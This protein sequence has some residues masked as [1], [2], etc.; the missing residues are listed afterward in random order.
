M[1]SVLHRVAVAHLKRTKSTSS[2]DADVMQVD[3]APAQTQD[4]PSLEEYLGRCISYDTS[5]SALRLALR[6]NL[7]EVEEV[8][9]VLQVLESWMRKWGEAEDEFGIFPA[10]SSGSEDVPARQLPELS[11]VFMFTGNVEMCL[12]DPLNRLSC[13]SK[14]H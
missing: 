6:K 2:P 7:G 1:I 3:P 12:T 13:S 5:A 8:S 14:R 4:I 11:K 10:S 9:A